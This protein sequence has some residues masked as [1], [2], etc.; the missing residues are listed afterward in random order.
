MRVGAL[1]L[2]MLSLA[3][4]TLAK[5]TTGTLVP[6]R[7]TSSRIESFGATP[8]KN[9]PDTQLE[10]PSS[11]AAL[12]NGRAVARCLWKRNAPTASALLEAQTLATFETAVHQAT[13]T[14]AECSASHLNSPN[15]FRVGFS[16][17]ALR[18]L[19]ADAG[20]RGNGF[21]QLHAASY[22]SVVAGSD[23]ITQDE[24]QKVVLRTADCLAAREPERTM[25]VIYA[26]PGSKEEGVAFMALL[27]LIPSCLERGVNLSAKRPMFRLA[28]AEAVDRRMRLA[29][30][31]A[32]KSK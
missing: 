13:A 22:S 5:Q 23:W 3:T 26:V 6:G 17:S 25:A 2:V 7:D 16:T 19:V 29:Q 1:L 30:M 10:L 4:P 24:G 11:E 27:P 12:D 32:E 9:H 18:G 15:V 14:I 8:L 20:L 31:P 21:P 28:L